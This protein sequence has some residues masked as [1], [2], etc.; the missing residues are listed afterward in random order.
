MISNAKLNSETS[1][2]KE[3]ARDKKACAPARRSTSRCGVITVLSWT[4]AA[5]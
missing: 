1:I 3:V 2:L 5:A 4:S